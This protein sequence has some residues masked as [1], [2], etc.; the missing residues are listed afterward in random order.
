MLLQHG[1]LQCS[2]VWLDTGP[3]RAL[4]FILADAGFDVWLVRC[5]PPTSLP[6]NLVLQYPR[7][8]SRATCTVGAFANIFVT[9]L[10]NALQTVHLSA[11]ESCT[12]VSATPNGSCS[13][14]YGS[15]LRGYFQSF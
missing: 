8:L 9:F 11:G 10:A 13:H 2:A 6:E 5:K 15:P 7:R 3:G 4:A 14:R 1:L 12:A